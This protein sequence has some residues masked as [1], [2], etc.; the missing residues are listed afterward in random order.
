MRRSAA[1]LLFASLV[2]TVPLACSEDA[3]DDDGANGGTSAGGSAGNAS[4]GKAG[5]SG[6]GVGGAG[7]SGTSGTAGSLTAGSGGKAG[8]GTGGRGGSAGAGV[9]GSV[10]GGA[11]SAGTAGALVGGNGGKGGSAGSG[12]EAGAVAGTAG[13]GGT[14]AGSGGAGGAGAGGTGGN[15]A[16][17]PCPTN[18]DPC[19]ILP[20]GDSI[21]DGFNIAGGYRMKLFSLANGD[22]HDITFVGAEQN[23]P[24]EVDGVPFPRNH[25]GH[26]GWKIN[27]L[28]DL[29]PDPAFD[30]TPHIVLLMIGT[31][32][33]N[34]SDNL[35]QAPMRLG[36]LVDQI[37]MT[38]PDALVVVAKITPLN[39]A[40]NTR[41]MTYNDA[42]PAVVMQRADA[43]KHVIMVDQFTDFPMNELADGIHPNQA[44][45]D[46]MAQVWYAA[47]E[48][49][50][51]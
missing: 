39:G 4:A 47:I 35:S 22:D 7:T 1:L 28:L 43:G 36:N 46:R 23:G 48:N 29:I 42:I 51:P 32:D 2:V 33:V 10:N 44:G 45:Y 24:T 3:A 6:S 31:N 18:G 38:A 5:G 37:V 19:R 17:A 40:G 12:G 25:E 49:L 9:S 50:L 11:N 8:G 34:Q 41:V 27:Q 13:A 15:S 20:F 21:T 26:S 14:A 30:V 16:F